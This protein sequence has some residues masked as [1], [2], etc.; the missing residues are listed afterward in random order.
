M[1]RRQKP[2]LSSNQASLWL[3]LRLAGVWQATTG[4]GSLLRAIG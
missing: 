3:A 4:F 2:V 1:K